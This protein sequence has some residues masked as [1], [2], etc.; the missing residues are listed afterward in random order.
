M[1][2]SEYYEMIEPGEGVPDQYSWHFLI[3]KGPHKDAVI[4]F[5]TVR[6][7]ERPDGLGYS[8]TYTMIR[9]PHG[10]DISPC[11]E[12]TLFVSKILEHCLINHYEEMISG[13]TRKENL[14][15]K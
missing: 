1:N 4:K 11:S 6:F 15:K 5:D 9:D 12:F 7:N 10:L 3:T 2:I 8:F 13:T 14:K